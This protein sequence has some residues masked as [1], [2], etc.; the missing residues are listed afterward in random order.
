MKAKAS[1]FIKISDFDRRSR[2]IKKAKAKVKELSVPDEKPN[3]FRI[4]PKQL[5]NDHP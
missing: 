5:Y 2:W 4:Y 1:T 3:S